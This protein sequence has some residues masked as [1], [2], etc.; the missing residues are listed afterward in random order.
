MADKTKSLANNRKNSSLI[1]CYMPRRSRGRTRCPSDFFN[2]DH[3]LQKMSADRSK[4]ALFIDGANLH[5]TAKVLGFG[6]DYGRLLKEFQSRGTLL[7]AF[8]Y[9]TIIEDQENSSVRPLLDWL[10]YNGYTVVTKA[11][12]EYFDSNGRR[13]IKGSMD[14]ELAVDAM[15]LADQIDEMVLFSG[16]G[17]L[18]R[19]VEAMQ[20]RGVRVTVV[21]TISTRPPMIAEELRR[22]SDLFTDLTELRTL[23]ARSN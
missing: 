11:A 22:Q 2:L 7:R 3:T 18:R 1:V 10:D 8:F 9:T 12:T 19:L 16:G 15:E 5:T 13:K 21:S 20:R 6:I 23:I 17:D 14:L 4:I